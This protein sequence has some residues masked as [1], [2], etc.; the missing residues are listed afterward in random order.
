MSV[1]ARLPGLRFAIGLL[2]IYG[3]VWTA[4]EGE[5]RQVVVLGV[6]ATVVLSLTLVQRWLGGRVFSLPAWLGTSTLAGL[7]VG[8]GSVL[9]TIFLMALKTGLHGHGP[10]FTPG[11][12]AWVWA[13][14]PLWAIAGSLLGLGVGLVAAALTRRR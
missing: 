12:I 6:W 9:M 5:L 3:L 8:A 11:E 1:P 13:Q 14:L 7:A 4:L 10:E 2:A